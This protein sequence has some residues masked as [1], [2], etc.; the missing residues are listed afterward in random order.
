[1]S[2]VV[3]VPRCGDRHIKTEDDHDEKELL[4]VVVVSDVFESGPGSRLESDQ[5]NHFSKP[6][7]NIDYPPF[8]LFSLS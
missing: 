8:L 6:N 5:I 3:I 4:R 7:Q 1:M 2:R